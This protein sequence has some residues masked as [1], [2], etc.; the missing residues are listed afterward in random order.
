MFKD[1]CNALL[2]T[3]KPALQKDMDLFESVNNFFKRILNA[4]IAAVTYFF[5]DKYQHG[6]FKSSLQQKSEQLSEDLLNL[7]QI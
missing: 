3:A 4:V 7:H 1:A 2:D 5:T 6:I